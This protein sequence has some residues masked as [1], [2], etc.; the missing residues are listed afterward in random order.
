MIE[1]KNDSLSI[2]FSQSLLASKNLYSNGRDD[3]A[4]TA[5]QTGILGFVVLL[6]N[7]I[8]S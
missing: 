3:V 4:T 1:E 8:L 5:A 6:I 2:V 7:S